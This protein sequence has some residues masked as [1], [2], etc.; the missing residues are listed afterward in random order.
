ML[1]PFLRTASSSLSRGLTV[2]PWLHGQP[3]R[4]CIRQF[5]IG[6][7]RKIGWIRKER[8]HNVQAAIRWMAVILA[9]VGTSLG[10]TPPPAQTTAPLT[11][12]PA[13]ATAP[14]TAAEA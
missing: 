1:L 12:A 7:I 14:A 3:R 10:Q 5:L 11:P 6:L 13:P 9:M 8:Q 4:A 2:A